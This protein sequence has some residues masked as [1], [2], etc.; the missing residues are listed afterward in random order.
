M[1]SIVK[2]I[3]NLWNKQEKEKSVQTIY[4]TDSGEKSEVIVETIDINE[5]K[6]VRK[7]DS[8]KRKQKHLQIIANRTKKFRIRKK[9]VKRIVNLYE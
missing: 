4:K 2:M 1:L 3:K 8:K 7:I 5:V 6:K 9:L